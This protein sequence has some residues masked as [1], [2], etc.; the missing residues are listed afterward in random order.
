MLDKPDLDNWLNNL[1]FMNA[2][3]ETLY[4]V[5]HVDYRE[6][7]V[8]TRVYRK[9]HET[10]TRMRSPLYNRLEKKDPDITPLSRRDFMEIYYYVNSEYTK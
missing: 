10:S 8:S 7:R 4:E 9:G 5:L 2:N 3:A 6:K 1:Y